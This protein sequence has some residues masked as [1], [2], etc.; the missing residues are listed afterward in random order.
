MKKFK[1]TT[2]I[3]ASRY[4]TYIVEANTPEEAY[5]KLQTGVG[6]LITSE[7]KLHREDAEHSFPEEI[8]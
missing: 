5:A 1:I 7:T 4:E 2:S 3:P 6:E 8:S